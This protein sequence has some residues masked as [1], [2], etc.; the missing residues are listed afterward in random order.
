MVDTVM[1]EIG[2]LFRTI[3]LNKTWKPD[4]DIDYLNIDITKLKKMADDRFDDLN[5]QGRFFHDYNNVLARIEL[6]KKF[7]DSKRTNSNDEQ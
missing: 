2:K 3:L 1:V 6:L 4:P 7:K 5:L